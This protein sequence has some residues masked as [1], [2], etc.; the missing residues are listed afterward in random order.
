MG[1]LIAFIG[2]ELDLVLVLDFSTTTDPV[3]NS[4]KD[5]SKRLVQQLKIGPHYTQVAAVTFAT[6]GRTRVRFNLKKYSTQ[7]EVLR[8]IDK[9][10]SKGGTTAIGAGIEKALT[11]IDESE[12]A[13]PGIATKVMIV[14]TDGWSNK[15]PDPEKRARDAVNA[16][17]EMYTVAYTARAPGSVTLNNETLSAISGSSG[18]A[19]T[20]VTFQTLVDKIKQRNLPCM[21]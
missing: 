19:F 7:E 17:F 4:Y 14:F 16:G 9:L 18:H 21:P 11:Q 2:C 5:L 13:R 12:G 15:G 6:V 1:A 8:G 10:Q 20:D 3:Y